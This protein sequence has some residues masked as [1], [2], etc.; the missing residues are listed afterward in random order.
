MINREEETTSIL[1][2]LHTAVKKKPKA[3]SAAGDEEP[4]HTFEE[5]YTAVQKK[6]KDYKEKAPPIRQCSSQGMYMYV[7][8]CT[9]HDSYTLHSLHVAMYSCICTPA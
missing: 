2:D 8:M 4:L 3:R 6:P 1:S 7:T 9:V 5:L